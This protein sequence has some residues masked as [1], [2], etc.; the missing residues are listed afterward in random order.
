MWEIRVLQFLVY[1]LSMQ[2]SRFLSAV[3]GLFLFIHFRS[4]Q[5]SYVHVTRYT[6]AACP[7]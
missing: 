5:I 6:T 4:A 3:F 1:G 2:V 7:K